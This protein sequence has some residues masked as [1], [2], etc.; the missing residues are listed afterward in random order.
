[1]ITI[2]TMDFQTHFFEYLDRVAKGETLQ[3]EHH[4]QEI[5]QV[6]P[7]RNW[8]EKMTIQPQLLVPLEQLINPLED[9]WEDYV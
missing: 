3:L 5:A 9:L 8:R 4:R 6:I 2:S 1:M 7:S